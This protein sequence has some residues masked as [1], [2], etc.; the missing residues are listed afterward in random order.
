[1]LP[2]ILAVPGI[3]AL[4]IP[5]RMALTVALGNTHD[6]IHRRPSMRHLHQPPVNQPLQSFFP[7]P[8][9]VAAKCPFTY[10]KQPCRFFLTQPHCPSPAM[11]LQNTSSVSLTIP[12]ASYRTSFGAVEPDRS[13]ATRPDSLFVLYTAVDFLVGPFLY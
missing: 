3:K 9:K 2:A 4:C 5:A 1:V 11:P 12:S 10:S 7:I 8:V 6:F 13:F